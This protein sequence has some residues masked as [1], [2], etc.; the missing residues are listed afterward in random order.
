[1]STDAQEKQEDAKS[2]VDERRT[3]W[4]P[5]LVTVFEQLVP[6]GWKVIPELL[7]NRLPQRVD[8]VIIRL[9]GT[10]TTT[11]RKLHSIF[12]YLR[13]HTLIEFKGPTDDLE[14]ID[15]LTLLGYACQYMAMNKVFEPDDVRLMVVADRI[16]PSFV[17]QIERLGGTFA[18]TNNGLWQGT[19]AGL[20][21]HGIELREAY[22]AG[23]S[24]NLLYIFCKKFL[25][26]PGVEKPV[27]EEDWAMYR[28]L[29]KQVVQF[30]RN[31]ETMNVRHID[32]AEERLQEAIDQYIQEMPL[33]KRFKGATP[34]QLAA[35][36][37]PEQLAACLTPEQRLAGL[38]LEQ[39]L[40]ALPPELARKLRA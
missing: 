28:L 11:V 13:K 3:A 7:L 12:D 5:M 17:K 25:K 35:R 16:P 22:K 34:E 19:L 32:I 6:A 27:D 23:Q 39:I 1:M 31:P 2:Q 18:P 33:E 15:A 4:H 29:R 8:I 30:W 9:E 38:T 36:L 37:T 14:A 10:P 24:E 26:H 40:A 20:S 21:L